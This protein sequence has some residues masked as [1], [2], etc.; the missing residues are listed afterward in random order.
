MTTP[1]DSDL[2]RSNLARCLGL[3]QGLL[4]LHRRSQ[5]LFSRRSSI[6]V[7]GT[8][9]S[10]NLFSDVKKPLQY[11]L[12]ILDLAR[13]SHVASPLLPSA[14]PNPSPV[15]FPPSPSPASSSSPPRAEESPELAAHSPTAL[16]M[17]ALNTLLCA[18]VDRPRNVRAFER[19]EGLAGIVKVLKD[20]SVAQVVRFVR[21]F[22][23]PTVAR[24]LTPLLLTLQDQSN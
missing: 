14:F 8:G 4:L 16:A 5:R 21:V 11:L 3:I 2:M 22:A 20:K 12:V 9:V 10:L 19:A 24:A 7:S 17:S 13:P 1:L 18:L 15:L 23:E 6:E